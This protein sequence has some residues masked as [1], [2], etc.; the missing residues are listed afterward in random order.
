MDEMEYRF[1]NANKFIVVDRK[2]LDEIRS[3]QMLQMSGE[4]DDKTIIKIGDLA[5]ANIV[6]TGQITNSDGNQRLSAKALDVRTGRIL[7]MERADI[8]GGTAATGAAAFGAGGLA[9]PAG[10]GAFKTVK[11]G[12]KT[13][14]AENLNVETPESRCYKD[15][16]A[17]CAKYG[18][19]YTLSAAKD[20]CQSLGGGWRLPTIEDWAALALDGATTDKE[21]KQDA[22][23]A[24]K[25]LKAQKSDWDGT[26]ERGFTALPGGYRMP[27]AVDAVGSNIYFTS[28]G[29]YGSWWTAT[30][31]A[32]KEGY[33]NGEHIGMQTGIHCLMPGSVVNAIVPSESQMIPDLK[34][35]RCVQ[36]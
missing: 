15:D 12:G 4:I 5:G 31:V 6:I 29:K 14:M 3:E 33:F 9:N 32:K 24:A 18:R 10:G 7:G 1:V 8:V 13:W 21:K 23:V 17:N 35:V 2:R 22:K 26:D 27:S 16:P 30:E 25:R 34:S 36:D 20:A 11:L 19:L 28:I